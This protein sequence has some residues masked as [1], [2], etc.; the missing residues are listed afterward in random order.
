MGA[1]VIDYAVANADAEEEILM[2]KEREREESDH[3]PIVVTMKSSEVEN[4]RRLD[5][6]GHRKILQKMH[7]MEQLKRRDE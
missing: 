1:S 6:G 7:K 2:V 5:G 3:L 4:D